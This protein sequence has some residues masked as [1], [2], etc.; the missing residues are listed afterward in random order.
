MFSDISGDFSSLLF[1]TATFVDRKSDKK[2]GKFYGKSDKLLRMLKI[3]SIF[4]S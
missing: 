2:R 4:A 1:E 3:F